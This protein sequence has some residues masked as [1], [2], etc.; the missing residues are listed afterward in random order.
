MV[1]TGF[2]EIFNVHLSLFNNIF[3]Q[4]KKVKKYFNKQKNV[5]VYVQF[6]VK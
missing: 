3:E 4:K 1:G 5:H 2:L 6:V